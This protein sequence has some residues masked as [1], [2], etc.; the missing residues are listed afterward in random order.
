MLGDAGEKGRVRERTVTALVA[1]QDRETA[2]DD[3]I[4]ATG[5]AAE[6]EQEA[7]QPSYSGWCRGRPSQ[8]PPL[9]GG[10]ATLSCRPSA[11]GLGRAP[12]WAPMP[13]WL[14]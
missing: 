4:A 10:I 12:R 14:L 7:A 6:Q 1:L 13:G 2:L 8:T 11:V 5:A 9:T 3:E